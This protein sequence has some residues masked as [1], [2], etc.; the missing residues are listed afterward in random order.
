[1]T[2][3]PDRLL[4]G[5][6]YNPEQ[7]TEEVWR[8]DIELMT[9]AR[10][11]TVTLGV[12]SWARLEPREGE[13]DT[14][15]LDRVIE[16][17]T[18]AGIGF[19]LAT[20][21]ASPPPWFTLAHPDALPVTP[22]G[23]RLTHGSRDTYA[24]S[25][26]AYR[27]A[28]RRV[29]RMLA[30]RYGSH[31]GLRG[32]HVHNEYG[33]LDYGPHAAAAFRR[34]LE[35]RYG[36]L[37]ALNAAWTT[38]FWSQGYGAWDEIFPP[39]ATQYVHNPAQLID[40]RRFSS[41]EML[42]CFSEQRDEI[43]AA[44]SAAPVTTNFMLPTWNHLEQWAWSREMDVVSVDH[45]LDTPGPD[46]EAHVAYGSDLV[47]GWGGGPWV[48]M[49]QN[50]TGIITGDRTYAKPASRMI[51]NSLGYIAR[52][53]Q[54]SL[55]FQWRA[56]LGGSEQWHGALVPH[57]GGS[58]AGYEA[59]CELGG[60][61]E[62]IS[63]VTDPPADGRLGDARVGIVWHADAWWAMETP[64]LPNDALTYRD[65]VRAA[66]RSF[67]R[68]GIAT[69]FLA[70]GADA[71]AYDLLVVP[72][73]YAAAPETA[74][75]LRGF[76]E[77][78]GTVLVSYLSG[79]ADAHLRILPGGYPGTFREL[80]GVSADEVRVLAPGEAVSLGERGGGVEIR[81]TEWTEHLILDGAETVLSYADGPSAGGPAVTRRAVG[82]GSAWYVSTVLEQASRDALY[83]R[84]AGELGIGEAVPG[85]A[86]LG[87]EAV[88]R[89]GAEADYLFLLNHSSSAASVAGDGVDLLSGGPAEGLEVAAGG[90]AV[91]RT[92][93]GGSAAVRPTM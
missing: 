15:W 26:P 41:D 53:S 52:G 33:T 80:L 45:Y 36:T 40:F 23:V 49:E 73:L 79:V 77:G 5:G 29:A 48:L 22:H 44:G 82:S 6:D 21:T 32:W 13:Y 10:V 91:I 19:F 11:N 27:E 81:A 28:A 92:P 64:H 85:A 18:V 63:E 51:R 86:A 16:M 87:L 9:R 88:R 43:R 54:S 62:K 38:G 84:I 59:V 74:E 20:P 93:R 37:E 4:F 8:E 72:C 58:S 71:S 75:W 55:F 61:L 56:S 31:P 35:A 66:H 78:G 34:W 14:S 70:P 90:V 24:I 12:F 1:M 7:W 65:E 47:R 39:V 57:A 3:V 76:A 89:R 60:M 50:A 42:A 30:E 69:D 68:A 46:G 2:F 17:L 25:A 67:W 83:A